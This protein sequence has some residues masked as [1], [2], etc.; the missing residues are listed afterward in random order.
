MIVTM[1]VVWMMKS[2]IDKIVDV[3]PV[4]DCLMPAAWSVSMIGAGDVWR[5]MHR[6]GFVNCDHML[7]NKISMHVVQMTVVQVISVAFVPNRR[8]PTARTVLM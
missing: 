7:I 6:V 5:A 2:P 1:T 8:M 4:R 3:I